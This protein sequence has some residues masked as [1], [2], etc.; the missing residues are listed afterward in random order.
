MVAAFADTVAE[1]ESTGAAL[2]VW[3]HGV[4]VVDVCRGVADARHGRTWDERT[5]TVLFSS[6]K[7]LAS[8]TV[9]WLAERGRIDLEAPVAK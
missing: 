2:S 6:T 5:P 4:E 3:H 1:P 8:L 7:G 9:A